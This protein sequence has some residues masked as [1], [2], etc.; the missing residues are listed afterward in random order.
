MTG[1]QFANR[2]SSKN[3]SKYNSNVNG[4]I[5]G[6]Q[7]VTSGVLQASNM[8]PVLFNAL[9]N[10]IDARLECLPSRFANNSK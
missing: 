1:E 10:Y 3:Y 7:L 4:V 8:G 2:T 9:I 5:S 6:W